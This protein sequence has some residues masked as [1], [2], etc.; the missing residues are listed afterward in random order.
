MLIHSDGFD[1]HAT[2]AATLADGD[3]LWGAQV[4][5]SINATGGRFGGKSLRLVATTAGY[6]TFN[7]SAGTNVAFAGW[8]KVGTISNDLP[9][10]WSNSQNLVLL[11]VD[12]SVQVRDGGGTQRTVAPAGSVPV[13]TFVWLEVSYRPG[14]ININVNGFPVGTAYVGAYT[15]ISLAAPRL[16]NSAGT[17]IGQVDVDDFIVWDDSGSFFNVYDL[18]PRRIQLMRPNADGTPVDWVPNGTTNWESVDAADWA[19]GAG[20]VATVNGTKDR[21]GFTSLAANPGSIDAVV[22]KTRVQNV[23]GDP[24]TLAHVSATPG[25]TEVASTPQAVAEV[26]PSTIKSAF[27]RDPVGSAWTP[28]TVN[29]AEFGQTLGV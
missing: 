18:A 24:A 17:G 16:L 13:D 7:A 2:G 5:V 19:G 25:G 1:S 6:L 23:G 28:S 12:R 22:V 29:A 8:F 14:G 15:A 4:G 11:K 3:A 26:A 21:Y 9:L 20:V 10:I 27:Y